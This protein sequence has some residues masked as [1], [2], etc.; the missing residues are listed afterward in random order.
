MYRKLSVALFARQKTARSLIQHLHYISGCIHGRC[1][2]GQAGLQIKQGKRFHAIMDCGDSISNG[3]ILVLR[4]RGSGET[5]EYIITVIS[6]KHSAGD[7]TIGNGPAEGAGHNIHT[8][9][10]K[11][12]GL[13][14]NQLP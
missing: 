11:G 2:I 1:Y 7:P 9:D 13:D 10:D 12:L 8:V 3:V 4:I 5:I 14:W 6:E